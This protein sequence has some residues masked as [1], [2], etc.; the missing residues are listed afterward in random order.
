MTSGRNKQKMFYA[1][2]RLT[3]HSKHIVPSRIYQYIRENHS[4][5]VSKQFKGKTYLESRGKKYAHEISEYQRQRIRESNAA[6]VWSEES[7]RRVSESQKRRYKERPE[8]FKGH[9]W[10]AESRH[11]MS[12]TKKKSAKRYVFMHKDG[13]V[14]EGSRSELAEHINSKACE[15]WKLTRGRYKSY[16]GWSLKT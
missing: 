4:R 15:I 1:L 13:S 16:K 14:F 9:K 5:Q 12:V 8:S 10:T 3:N 7:K 2:H 6:R 11:K